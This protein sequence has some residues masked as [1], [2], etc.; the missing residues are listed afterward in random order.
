MRDHNVGVP[1][2]ISPT[3]TYGNRV[4]WNDAVNR[5]WL[6]DVKEV[7]IEEGTTGSG[8]KYSLSVEDIQEVRISALSSHKLVLDQTE[9]CTTACSFNNY[10]AQLIAQHVGELYPPGNCL[11]IIQHVRNHTDSVPDSDDE[12]IYD[13]E[14]PPSFT[15]TELPVVE[16]CYKRLNSNFVSVSL[17]QR[18]RCSFGL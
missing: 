6:T 12:Q 17:M 14:I 7:V 2:Q 5:D 10:R 1:P 15:N 9:I 18:E 11:G 3:A 4:A 13:E 8:Q 16:A